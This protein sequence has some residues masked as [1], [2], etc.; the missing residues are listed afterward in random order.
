M[1]ATQRTMDA[2]LSTMESAVRSVHEGQKLTD[3]NI[4][5]LMQQFTVFG[6][7]MQQMQTGGMLAPTPSPTQ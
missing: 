5:L 2:K 6:K 3:N 1:H 7:Q 4:Q